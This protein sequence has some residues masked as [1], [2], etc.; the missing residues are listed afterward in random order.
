MALIAGTAQAFGPDVV[1]NGDFESGTFAPDTVP[2]GW[3]MGGETSTAGANGTIVQWKSGSGNKWVEVKGPTTY[4]I[5]GIIQRDIAVPADTYGLFSFDAKHVG[6]V[7]SWFSVML[8]WRDASGTRIG[9]DNMWVG[10][11]FMGPYGGPTYTFTNADF[12]PSVSASGYTAGNEWWT[13]PQWKWQVH[14]PAGT[15]TVDIHF[16]AYQD[17]VHAFDNVSLLIPE[18]LALSLLGLGGLMLRRRK[19]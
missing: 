2:P 10:S 7:S 5:A 8:D 3:E 17:C 14:S 19:K 15:A 9:Y 13:M 11:Y 16:Y 6:G 18:P 12:V 1:I 4:G